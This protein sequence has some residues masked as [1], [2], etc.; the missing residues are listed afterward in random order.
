MRVV[1]Q[2]DGV[3]FCHLH[4]VLQL[5]AGCGEAVGNA[6]LAQAV[7][8]LPPRAQGEG[9]KVATSALACARRAAGKFELSVQFWSW[10]SS[11]DAYSE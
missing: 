8:P 7:G 9:Q 11:L 3:L 2:A 10:L 6:V 4:Q 1:R 5:A